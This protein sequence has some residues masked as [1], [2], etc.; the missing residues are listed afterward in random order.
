MESYSGAC[1]AAR[2][3]ALVKL[4]KNVIAEWDIVTHC[5]SEPET[6]ALQSAF[7]R[8]THQDFINWTIGAHTRPS[9]NSVEIN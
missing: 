8:F 1:Q 5:L 9:F 3:K 4:S 6:T 2:R 7:S